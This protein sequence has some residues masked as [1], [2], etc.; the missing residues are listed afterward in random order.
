RVAAG[1]RAQG[2]AAAG[3]V[4]RPVG[5]L[6]GPPRA[7]LPPRLL[8]ATGHF[9]SGL[10][11]LRSPSRRGQL[12]GDDLV[13]HRHVGL[14]GEQG[15]V[16]LDR[17]DGC[18]RE[19]ADVDG[20]HYVVTPFT[21]LRMRTVAPRGPGTAPLMRTSWRSGSA[22]TTWR[23][24]VVTF[25]APRRPAMRVPRNTRAGVAQAPMAP[26][27]LCFLWL[28]WAAGWPLKLW[29]FMGPAKPR[30]RLTAV[31]STSSPAV[32]RS[33]ASSWPTWNSLVSST[34]SSTSFLPASTRA[35]AKWPASGRFSRD[36]FTCP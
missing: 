4:R 16:E 18:P 11:A 14:D 13:H 6:P 5:A 3:P 24:R 7:L 20:G 29:R 12:G 17:A 26:G 33:A 28:P 2:D 34:R 31:T 15:V 1:L 21:A 27:A 25:W 36:A 35:L 10:R 30:P 22:S 23:L 9:G 32:R 8:A 19:V